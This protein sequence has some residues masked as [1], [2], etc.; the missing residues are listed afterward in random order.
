MDVESHNQKPQNSKNQEDLM[1][2]LLTCLSI[3]CKTI[4]S[5]QK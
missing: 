5:N 3:K 2:A 1:D 4:K